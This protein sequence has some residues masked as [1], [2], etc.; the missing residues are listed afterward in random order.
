MPKETIDPTK[1]WRIGSLAKHLGVPKTTLQAAA[2]R[3]EFLIW[4]TACGIP[5][6]TE[7][8]VQGWLILGAGHPA[9]KPRRWSYEPRA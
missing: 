8:A 4:T 9:G 7:A 2:L 3:G 6:T 5:M 1:L